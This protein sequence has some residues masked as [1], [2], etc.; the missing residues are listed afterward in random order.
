[1][2]AF[3]KN[4][5]FRDVIRSLL[6]I[7]SPLWAFSIALCL[8]D[9]V[10]AMRARGWSIGSGMLALTIGI[11]AVTPITAWMASWLPRARNSNLLCAVT[12]VLACALEF[13]LG[14]LI[15]ATSVQR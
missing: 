5:G 10:A 13:V 15:F 1:M 14:G 11:F 4:L 7:A 3:T 9:E 6:L 2:N 8:S 12:V